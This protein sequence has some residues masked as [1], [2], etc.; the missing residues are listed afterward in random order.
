MDVPFMVP[1]QALSQAGEIDPDLA[2]EITRE[3]TRSFFD[4]HL[5]EGDV[6]IESLATKYDMLEMEVY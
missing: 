2:I 6:D 1:L 3:L 5:K 4:R